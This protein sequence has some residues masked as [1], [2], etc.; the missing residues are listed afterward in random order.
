MAIEYLV[1]ERVV[2][3]HERHPEDRTNPGFSGVDS[4]SMTLMNYGSKGWRLIS[5]ITEPVSH[6]HSRRVFYLQREVS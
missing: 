2:G 1:I 5:V 4:E 6:D 3:A